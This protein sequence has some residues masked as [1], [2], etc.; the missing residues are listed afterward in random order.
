MAFVE[1]FAEWVSMEMCVF[2]HYLPRFLK[3]SI[4]LNTW[5]KHNNFITG[6]YLSSLLHSLVHYKFG[7]LTLWIIHQGILCFVFPRLKP[8]FD[9]FKGCL[10]YWWQGKILFMALKKKETFLSILFTADYE[11]IAG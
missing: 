11:H 6:G 1:S 9:T 4:I 2:V 7:V 3:Q 10:F 8:S 5:D